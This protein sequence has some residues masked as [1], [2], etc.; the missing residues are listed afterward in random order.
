MEKFD[1]TLTIETSKLAHEIM[2]ILNG[3]SFKE[4]TEAYALVQQHLMV[5]EVYQYSLKS[6]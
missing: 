6:N 1:I 2:H 3:H 5:Q 4:I